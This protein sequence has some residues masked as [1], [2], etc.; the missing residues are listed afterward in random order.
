[1]QLKWTELAAADPDRIEEYIS[2]G[3]SPVVATDVV[4]NGIDAVELLLPE[5]PHAGRPGRLKGTRELVINGV[6][7]VVIYRIVESV[8]QLQILRVIH[9]SQH[10]PVGT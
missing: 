2:E 10:W 8:G 6:P 7:F 9:D 3:N 1:V 5:H 4:L